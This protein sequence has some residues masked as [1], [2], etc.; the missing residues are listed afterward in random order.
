MFDGQNVSGILSYEDDQ[1][2]VSNLLRSMADKIDKGE[3]AIIVTAKTELLHQA[4]VSES[5]GDI[6][7]KAH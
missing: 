1:K 3:S 2:A 7:E 5:R 6:H 4:L